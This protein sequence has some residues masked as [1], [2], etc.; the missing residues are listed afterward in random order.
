[1]DLAITLA[2]QVDSARHLS[3]LQ[4]PLLNWHEGDA[5]A[6]LLDELA[7]V[8]GDEPLAELAGELADRLRGRL[9]PMPGYD[10]EAMVAAVLESVERRLNLEMPPAPPD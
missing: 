3:L 9:G 8:L 2:A 1:M 6:R 7:A 5:V 4:Q 10:P